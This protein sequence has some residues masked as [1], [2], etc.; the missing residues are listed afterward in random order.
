[1]SVA[2]PTVVTVIM[3]MMVVVMVVMVMIVVVVGADMMMVQALAIGFNCHGRC[4][5]SRSH[6][7][8]NQPDTRQRNQAVTGRFQCN[9]H[10]LRGAGGRA[11]GQQQ[12]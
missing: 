10:G 12:G 6:R 4:C 8:P 7:L 2:A 9:C 1:M 3:G 5:K 11:D